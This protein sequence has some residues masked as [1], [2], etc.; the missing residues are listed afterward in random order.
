MSV[1]DLIHPRASVTEDLCYQV[2]S[3]EEPK[4]ILFG[5]FKRFEDRAAIVT[6][7]Q[8]SGMAL[9]HLAHENNLPF[10]VCTLDTLRLFAETYDFFEQVEA[11]YGIQIE[12]IT[13][14][15]EEV[16]RMVSRHGEHL[17]FDS[18]DKQNHCCEIRKVRPMQRLLDTLDVWLTG[19]RRDQSEHRGLTPKS[20][21]INHGGRSVLK[22]NP[23]AHWTE[24]QVWQFISENDVP[25]NPLL[26]PDKHGAY[27]ESLG[28]VICTTRILPGEPK[29]AG[30]W[31]WQNAAATDNN[32]E[33]G[34][35]FSI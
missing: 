18:K 14:D 32:K 3:V 10:R 17:F 11:R 9:I 27:F 8:L 24:E 7:G 4:E 21:L 35:H 31:R 13:P 34:L 19:L 20:E 16:D 26:K 6:S 28:C 5:L 29:R 15:P 25:V 23:L 12:R 2:N 22:V 33:C 1:T 30:R